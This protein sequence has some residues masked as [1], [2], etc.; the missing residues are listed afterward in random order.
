[1]TLRHI[2]T[3]YSIK[4]TLIFIVIYSIFSPTL[5][6]YNAIHI[7]LLIFWHSVA[8]NLVRIVPCCIHS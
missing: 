6:F 2:M 1:M 4:H 7:V 3:Y 8:H 5:S